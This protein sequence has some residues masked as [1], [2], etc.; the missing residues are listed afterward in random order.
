MKVKKLLFMNISWGIAR[1]TLVEFA[2]LRVTTSSVTKNNLTRYLLCKIHAAFLIPLVFFAHVVVA[3]NEIV[4]E[5][6]KP[7]SPRSEWDVTGAGDPDI[8]GFATEM[9]VNKGETVYFKILTYPHPYTIDIYRIGY[10]QG[11]G[12]RKVGKG[13]IMANLPQIQPDNR[14]DPVTGLI[15]CSN[16]QKSAYWKVPNDAVSGV[17]IAKLT[18]STGDANHIIFIVRDDGSRSDLYFKTSDATW[19]AYNDWGGNYGGSSLYYGITPYTNGRA[20]KVSYN[21]PFMTRSPGYEVSFFFSAEYA[22]VRWLERNGYHVSYTTDVD[23]DRRGYLIKNH[24]VFLSVGHD[25]YW[26]AQERKYVEEARNA[27]VHLAFFSGN[28]VYWKTRWELAPD[29]ARNRILVCY[30]E[31]RAGDYACPGKC[32]PLSNVWTGL[33]RSGCEFPQADGCKPENSLTGQLGYLLVNDAI[34]VPSV[35]KQ[36]RFWRN[37]EVSN[38]ANGQVATLSANTL[39]YEIDFEQ[40]SADYPASRVTM[41]ETFLNGK[42][43]KLSL[44][45]HSSG[46]L[47]FGAGTIQWSYGLDGMHDVG[48][49]PDP[50]IQ[51]ATVNLFADMDVLPS[52]LQ[53]GLVKSKPSSD[54]RPPLS[55]IFSPEEKS[56][57]RIGMPVTITGFAKDDEGIVARVE[58]STDDGKTWAPA[59]GGATWSFTWTPMFI[60]TFVIKSRSV[61]DLGNLEKNSSSYN[62]TL[63]YVK[64]NTPLV[65]S[66]AD[67]KAHNKGVEVNTVYKG[68]KHASSITLTAEIISGVPPYE[69]S[70]SNGSSNRSIQVS[71]GSTATYTVTVIDAIDNKETVSVQI[72]VIDARCGDNGKKNDWNDDKNNDKDDDQVLVCRNGKTKCVKKHQVSDELA[73]GAMLGEC[74]DVSV[75]SGN[76][77]NSNLLLEESMRAGTLEVKAIPNPVTTHFTL[78]IKTGDY[79][80]Q[81]KVKVMSIDGRI[82]ENRSLKGAQMV[83]FGSDYRPGMYL[84]EVVQGK[85]R[86]LMK[87]VKQ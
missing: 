2:F 10:Y 5:N 79:V 1:K 17:Y 54:R 27:G 30:K 85:K 32:D 53:T 60:G 4:I 49:T 22:M 47:V 37:S 25:E 21:R 9:S 16:W 34:K 18:L 62:T 80:E 6:Q 57:L 36:Y 87:L 65:V 50:R 58:V 61:D 77:A 12:A 28:E 46:A 81:V 51:Q 7:G 73:E 41:S 45:R 11:N 3:Q 44:Y 66:I 69:Y 71:P 26:S 55:S 33:W 19:Q 72:T 24:Q 56:N 82:I 20:V 8:Q 15:D 31:G 29:G 48:S 59:I 14:I 64:P 75:L 38:L 83:Q 70:W 43:H 76:R 42:T 78:S 35:Y 68:Y 84:V 23:A 67:S 52:T 63:V 86:I 74:S 13:V 39:G 40:E